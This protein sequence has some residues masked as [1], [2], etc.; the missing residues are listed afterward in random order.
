MKSKTKHFI[1]SLAGALL[2]GGLSSCSNEAEP[3][4]PGNPD[5]KQK[6]TLIANLGDA[7]TRMVYE[8][9][10]GEP[11]KAKW[12]KDDALA[13]FGQ[14]DVQKFTNA[15]Q[16]GQTESSTAFSGDSPEE[17]SP[18]IVFYPHSKAGTDKT[19]LTLTATGQKQ[20]GNDNM[21]HIT[22]YDYMTGTATLTDEL[23][24]ATATVNLTRKMA[25]MKFVLTIPE[26][27]SAVDGAVT[28]V[29]MG[30]ADTKL[31]YETQIL[32]SNTAT[33]D[34]YTVSLNL[35]NI[36]DDIRTTPLTAYMMF[37]PVDISENDLTIKVKC[38]NA[39][40][41]Y[42]ASVSKAYDAGKYYTATI[43]DG[44]NRKD[45]PTVYVAGYDYVGSKTAA[46]LWT[47]GV[48]QPL[49]NVANNAQATSVYVYGTSVYVAGTEMGSTNKTIATLWTD[50]VPETL[51]DGSQKSFATS[52]HVSETG[53]YV[54]VYEDLNGSSKYAAKVWGNGSLETLSD[55]TDDASA[56]SVYVS[57]SDVYVGGYESPNN[58]KTAT[59]WTNNVG[60]PLTGGTT[61]AQVTSVY[62][63]GTDVYMAGIANNGNRSIAT[64]WKNNDVQYF[65]D[66]TR[67]AQATS[68]YMYGSDVY[69]AG[70]EQNADNKYVAIVWKNGVAQPLTK[71]ETDAQA[72]SVYVFD[73]D[74]Y[75]A[76]YEA[77]AD[78][79]YVAT[80]WKNGVAQPL[81]DGTN[82]TS[83]NSVFVVE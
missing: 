80:L 42:T 60:Q 71:G 9:E 75:V 7:G 62:V 38:E 81:T 8:G 3:L 22:D 52:V 41:T 56:N 1:A 35:E 76:G 24:S 65:T 2:I 14:T 72:Y 27:D 59:L 58:K 37:I 12:T 30:N 15:L 11:F 32:G 17:A 4:A 78:G 68:V 26:Y 66:G 79:N 74:I 50:G 46:F 53:I 51:T 49:S 43:S 64:L 16:E 47:N 55:A 83:A 44:W 20:S 10:E 61:S 57:G 34:A 29:S 40:Y 23:G 31:F 67:F 77:N 69:V 18:Y 73:G 33:A 70:H 45:P 63:S 54:A 21:D 25:M 13:V 5:E 82:Y 36:T 6:L 19:Q 39:S 48:G 28:K